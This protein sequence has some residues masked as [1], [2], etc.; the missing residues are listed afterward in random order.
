MSTPGKILVIDDELVG[1]Q[2]LEAMLTPE[3]YH[4]IFGENGKQGLELVTRESP[5]LILCD[6]MMPGIDGFEVCKIIRENKNTEHIPIFLI[7]ALDD[8]DSKIRGIVAGADDYISKPFNRVEILAKINNCLSRLK[9]R[10]EIKSES[11]AYSQNDLSINA[12]MFESLLVS[13]CGK[14]E[15]YKNIELFQSSRNIESKHLLSV[16]ICNNNTYYFLVSNSLKSHNAVILNCTLLSTIYQLAAKKKFSLIELINTTKSKLHEIVTSLDLNN[17]GN[18]QFSIVALEHDQDKQNVACSGT[19]QTFLIDSS[20][21]KT[22]HTI[23]SS[24]TPYQINDNQVIDI[25]K[26]AKIIVLSPNIINQVNQVTLCSYIN[27]EIE[28]NGEERL[29]SKISEYL[30]LTQ[31]VLVAKLTF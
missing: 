27:A 10:K 19:N 20:G 26:D 31:D 23:K 6:V 1:R 7:T 5:D 2:L 4:V 30:N 9:S 21:T 8:R 25:D 11:I 18:F 24:Y 12:G 16:R 14:V 13:L 15:D 29:T 28:K 22:D 3:N 17:D